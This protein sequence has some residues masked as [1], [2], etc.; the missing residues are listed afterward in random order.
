MNILVTYDGSL[1]SKDA[2]RYGIEKTRQASGSLF[3]LYVFNRAMFIDYE[4]GLDAE[5]IARK[6]STLHIA[7]A[8]MIIDE[9][10]KGLD[11][12]IIEE[13]GHPEE[14]I[15][16]FVSQKKVDLILSIPR[17]KS[18][19]KKAP[20][21]VS[22]I[23]GI[24]L[25]PVDN[26]DSYEFAIPNVIKEAKA[27]SSKVIILGIVPVHLYSKS[28]KEELKK[29]EKE[30]LRR[31]K[32]AKK[33]LSDNGIEV[34]EMLRRGFVDE[35]ILRCAQEYDVSMIIIPN[36]NNEP[37]ELKKAAEIINREPNLLKAPLF[38]LPI[39]I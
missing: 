20:C 12:E 36:Y 26:T 31:L 14:E 32:K 10:G 8:R 28:E 11:I 35:E 15:I 21:P 5:K 3:V 7:D 18:I 29:I 13:E 19:V 23:P 6:E 38:Q 22:I 9:I 33:M 4:G 24:I 27:T 34:K 16:N 25:M 39:Y 17:Y 1:N 37:S 2:L 30:T